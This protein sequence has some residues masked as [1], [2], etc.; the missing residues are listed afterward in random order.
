MSFA[1]LPQIVV[2]LIGLI[3]LQCTELLQMYLSLM[4][5]NL[6]YKLLRIKDSSC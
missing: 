3:I 6:L 2:K 5:K 4:R 1:N